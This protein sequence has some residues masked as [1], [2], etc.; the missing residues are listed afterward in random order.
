MYYPIYKKKGKITKVIISVYTT[1]QRARARSLWKK[2]YSLRAIC[3]ELGIK[4][5]QSVKSMMISKNIK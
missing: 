4:G 3:K 2:G 5:A 1:Q